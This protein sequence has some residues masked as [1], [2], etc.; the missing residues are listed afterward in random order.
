MRRYRRNKA[1]N[2]MRSGYEETISRYLDEQGV[3]YE[4]EKTKV[5]YKQRV[6]RGRCGTCE[7]TDVYVNRTY[8]PDFFIPASGIYI[9]AKGRFT[10]ADRTKMLAVVE[11]NP[12]LDIRML[13]M[14]DNYMTKKRV[15]KYSDWC[16]KKGIVFF[17]CKNGKPPQSWLE[18]DNV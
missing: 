6:P 10:P 16:R 9:E 18:G 2:G 4:Y 1:V 5:S 3:E 12:D 14:I 11:S 8:T 7:G 15:G 13:F 17:V